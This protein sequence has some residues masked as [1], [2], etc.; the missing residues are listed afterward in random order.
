MQRRVTVNRDEAVGRI[1]DGEAIVINLVSG[2]YYSTIGPGAVIWQGIE[3]GCTVDELVAAVTRAYDVGDEIARQDVERLVR[4]MAA[5]NLVRTEEATVT[6]ALAST[7]PGATSPSAPPAS[8][9]AAYES[10]ALHIY[11]DMSD[12]LALDPPMPVLGEPPADWENDPKV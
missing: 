9:R 4:E 6:G 7:S 8:E 10:P 11:R 12:L 2:A 3:D 5:E 1:L